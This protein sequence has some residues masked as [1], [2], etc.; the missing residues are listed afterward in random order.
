[1]ALT[2]S[3]LHQEEMNMTN[4]FHP[5]RKRQIPKSL[6]MS[7][8]LTASSCRENKLG[9]IMIQAADT[10]VLV[11]AVHIFS[12]FKSIKHLCIEENLQQDVL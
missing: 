8:I 3:V 10:D 9:S 11:L 4:N 7:S 6:F 2:H 12:Q 1:M 5:C